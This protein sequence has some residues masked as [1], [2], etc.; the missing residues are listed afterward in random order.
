MQTN[1]DQKLD[2]LRRYQRGEILRIR[3]LSDLLALYDLRTV[4]RQ[5]SKLASGIVRACLDLASQQSG[6]SAN[7]FVV[8]ALGKH[9][10]EE[11]NYSS[12]IDLLFVAAHDPMEK[13]KT[14][15]TPD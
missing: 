3:R 11:L 6:I 10:A 13:L 14:R 7:D 12:D 15:R 4:T 9:G 1:T 8:I 5:L 2:A